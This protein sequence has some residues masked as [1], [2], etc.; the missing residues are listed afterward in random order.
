MTLY[1][2]MLIWKIV[3]IAGIS[4]FAILAV[5]VTIGGLFDIRRLFG[6][7]HAQHAD[8]EK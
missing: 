3:L 5:V 1:Q 4:M 2:W 7:L 8:K 6:I